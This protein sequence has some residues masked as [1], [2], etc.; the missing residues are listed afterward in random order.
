MWTFVKG[1]SVTFSCNTVVLVDVDTP[2]GAVD[3]IAL[4]TAKRGGIDKAAKM[5]ADQSQ[6][7]LNSG[8]ARELIIRGIADCIFVALLR[9]GIHLAE[10]AT[11]TRLFVRLCDT[12]PRWVDYDALEWRND[13]LLDDYALWNG[14][15]F[16]DEH[17]LLSVLDRPGETRVSL[18]DL[19]EEAAV[20]EWEKCY[21][22]PVCG[23]WKL[24]RIASACLMDESLLPTLGVETV[25]STEFLDA[26]ANSCDMPA[27]LRQVTD[28][29]RSRGEVWLAE[30]MK[31]LSDMA[32]GWGEHVSDE[33][34]VTCED[35]ER[36]MT[37]REVL[38][39]NTGEATYLDVPVDPQVRADLVALASAELAEA[40]QPERRALVAI[41]DA[42]DRF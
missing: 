11:A 41:I 15:V 7:C 2:D 25:P 32:T 20:F 18:P 40:T 33:W 30:A 12:S 38:S 29:T 16:Q 34:E 14:W 42:C 8:I 31:S 13:Y 35:F 37:L 5:V 22:Q 23:N 26:I 6:T 36:G 27:S 21:Y 17:S 28:P 19:L 4:D 39:S 24:R 1:V 3:T 10:Y 9:Q